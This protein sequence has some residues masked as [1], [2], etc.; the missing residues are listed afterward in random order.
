MKT[1]CAG[2]CNTQDEEKGQ[3]FP[4]GNLLEGN[5]NR[6]LECL[7]EKLKNEK[8]LLYIYILTTIEI[9]KDDPS[10]KTFIQ[11][12]SAPNFQGGHITLCS[13]KHYMRT[14]REPQ[15]GKIFG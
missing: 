7:K 14:L 3:P 1:K 13:C 11:T 4:K 8:A 2:G 10:D 6:S 9:D 5:M 15:T 12:G